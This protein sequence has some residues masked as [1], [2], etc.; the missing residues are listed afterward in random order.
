MPVSEKSP[1][2][3]TWTAFSEDGDVLERTVAPDDLLPF[4]ADGYTPEELASE[5][6]APLET[7]EHAIMCIPDMMVWRRMHNPGVAEV[8]GMKRLPSK[9]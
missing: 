9:L 5:F 1:F 7:I 3:A 8:N 6:D 2:G 4:I